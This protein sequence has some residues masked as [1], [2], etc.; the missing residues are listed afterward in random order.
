MTFAWFL[1]RVLWCSPIGLLALALGA[2]PAFLTQEGHD[3][4][5]EVF[6]YV[7]WGPTFLIPWEHRS[8]WNMAL[9]NAIGFGAVSA[10]LVT[11]W[12]I[13]KK[14]P[15]QSPEPTRSVGP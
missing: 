15:N 13:G 10:A 2:I 4:P 7:L 5:L 12:R 9:L 11:L 1:K 8:W 14:E 3:H 6:V